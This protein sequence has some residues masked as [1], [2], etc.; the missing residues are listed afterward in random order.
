MRPLRT[1][2]LLA[3]QAGFNVLQDALIGHPRLHL[4]S[5]YTH[6]NLPRAEGGGE[7]AEVALFEEACA[8]AGV[9]LQC[10]D[11]AAAKNLHDRLPRG[12]LDLLVSVSWRYLVP[13][14]VLQ[15]L[16]CGALNLHRGAL[17]EYAGAEPVRRA[18][19]AGERRVAITAHRMT[20]EIDAGPAIAVVW[21][22][23]PP[24]AHGM[25]LLGH[26]EATRR[27]LDPLYAPLARAAIAA[28]L[29]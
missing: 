26:V 7:R 24:L 1:V 29:A 17:P 5:V 4:V 8:G 12:E 21:M 23:V 18:I 11:G 19:A 14:P 22:D 20:A 13:S 15:R 3:R 6:R 27:R 9:A 2:A 28:M 16:R 10:L 25:D